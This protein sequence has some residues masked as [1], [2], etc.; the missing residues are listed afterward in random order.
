MVTIEGYSSEELLSLPAGDLD[1]L[2]FIGRPAVVKIGSAELLAECRRQGSTLI[3]DLAHIDGGG[4]GALPTLTAF[5]NRFAQDRG[6]AEI[7]WIVRA[8]DCARPN[9][10]LQRILV[11][12]GFTVRRLGAGGDCYYKMT[13]IGT[14]DAV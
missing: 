14:S 4:E 5:L 6:F 1:A 12:K 7:E 13:P 8:T 9:E 2:V 11:R 3:V 10:R